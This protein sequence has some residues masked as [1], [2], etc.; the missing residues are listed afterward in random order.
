MAQTTGSHMPTSR[1]AGLRTR[2][3]IGSTDG[4]GNF[5]LARARKAEI[6]APAVFLF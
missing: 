2:A 1:N 3:H 6:S 4:T 5:G